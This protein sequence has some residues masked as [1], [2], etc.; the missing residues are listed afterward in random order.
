M[1]H[2]MDKIKPFIF[3]A[4]LV[5]F[6]SCRQ[7]QRNSE[8]KYQQ[9]HSYKE[10]IK[11]LKQKIETIDSDFEKTTYIRIKTAELIDRGFLDGQRDAKNIDNE[12]ASWNGERYYNVFFYDSATVLCGGAANFLS[13]VYIDLGYHATTYDMGIANVHT[14][15]V[16][17]VLPSTNSDYYVQDAFNNLSFEDAR[18]NQPLTFKKLIKMLNEKNDSLIHIILADYEFKSTMDT[19][20][21]A[22]LTKTNPNARET[23][24]SISKMSRFDFSKLVVKYKKIYE[25]YLLPKGYPDNILYL[26]LF[27]LKHN[28]QEVNAIV[29]QQTAVMSR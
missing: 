5:G 2:T 9:H 17:L 8:P 10:F 25:R 22:R 18:T 26:Y 1:A 3:I 20:G 7:T 12:W 29:Q 23:F 27:P 4:I 28:S 14:H 15:Q 21:I 19:T 16:T 24:D 11:F 6:C 13:H